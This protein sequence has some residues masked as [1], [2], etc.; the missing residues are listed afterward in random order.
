MRA[1]R[2]SKMN[3]LIGVMAQIMLI[4]SQIGRVFT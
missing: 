4:D 1:L 3:T 2:V